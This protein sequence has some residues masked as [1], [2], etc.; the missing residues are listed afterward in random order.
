MD[1]EDLANAECAALVGT[2]LAGKWHLDRLVGVGGMAAVYAATHRNGRVA[3]IK[4]LHAKYASIPEVRGRFLKE[5][6]I[7][8][9]VNHPGVVRV[10]DDEVT[11]EGQPLLVMELLQGSSLDQVLLDRGGT[12]PVGEAMRL[13]E[14][15]LDVM[16]LAHG[17]GIVHRDLKPENLFLTRDGELKVLDF[18]IARLLEGT[19]GA[20]KTRTGLVM[21]TPAYMAPEQALGRWAQVDARTDL[22]AVGAIAFSMIAGRMVHEAASANEMLVIAASRPAPSLARFSDAPI[23][24]VRCIDKA[25]AYDQAK[26]FPDASTMHGDVLRVL[27][28]LELS[29]PGSV[30]PQR[31]QSSHP[32]P[33]GV[34]DD[35]RSR[36]APGVVRDQRR[37]DSPILGPASEAETLAAE[38]LPQKPVTQQ[39][40]APKPATQRPPRASP[41]VADKLD[42]DFPGSGDVPAVTEAFRQIEHALFARQQY[43]GE[44]P[45]TARQLDRA[46]AACESALSKSEE[47]V[48]WQVAPYAFTLEA[49]VVWEPRAPFDRIPYQLFAD[50]LRLLGFI[51]GV[52]RAELAALIRIIALDRVRD[53]SADDDFVT[54]LWDA[55]FEHV[56]YQAID[57]FNEGDQATREEFEHS[58]G[59]IAALAEFDTSFQLEECWQDARGTKG[60]ETASAREERLMRL[61][62]MPD[63]NDREA[64]VRAESFQ[65]RDL[66][67]RGETRGAVDVDFAALEV[68]RARFSDSSEVEERLARVVA[69]AFR[70]GHKH[71]AGGAVAVPLRAALDSLATSAPVTLARFIATLL[72]CFEDRDAPGEA[73]ELRGALSSEAIGTSA[74]RALLQRAADP[75]AEPSFAAA[76]REILAVAADGFV[77]PVLAAIAA[78]P[79]AALADVLSDYVARKGEGHEEAIA[80]LFAQAGLDLG[81]HLVRILGR[82]PTPAARAAVLRASQSPHAVVRIE[83]LSHAEGGGERLRL[84]L[85]ALLEDSEPAV[86]T[87]ALRAIK[88]RMIRAAGPYLVLRIKAP[89]FDKLPLEERRLAL[90]TLAALAPARAEAICVEILT[91]ARL[92]TIEAHEES[93]ALAAEILGEIAEA[94]ESIQALGVASTARWR[95]SERVRSMAGRARDQ[96]EVRISQR[97]PGPVASSRA[98][99]SQSGPPISLVDPLDLAKRRGT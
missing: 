95:Y 13:V 82:I 56:V 69:E 73:R 72:S 35:R 43:G 25:L 5:A 74:V 63:T 96:A 71:G 2:Q 94:P 29:R 66:D 65:L 87:A 58:A 23:A 33:A 59:D 12:L 31:K 70:A 97:P 64:L 20:S 77:E 8:N 39:P 99:P 51:R 88:D 86:R 84:E 34:P 46:F 42:E 62:A 68:M 21:G 36:P 60:P 41:A 44:H 27:V 40:P 24:V 67:A 10:E 79:P 4:L 28:E 50:G 92:V 11:A 61:L 52:T 19:E 16:E 9:K 37:L 6:R 26:R 93:R 22:W 55:N 17:A 80:E 15:L 53:F 78:G 54:L 83:A 89:G 30:S 57:A 75:S 85:R 98:P 81:L 32:A 47:A 3:A 45:E 14:K 18:G 90:A 48:V 1:G 38:P 49:A 76:L 7:A 91:D